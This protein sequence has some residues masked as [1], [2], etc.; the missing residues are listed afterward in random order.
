MKSKYEE[1]IVRRFAIT[2]TGSEAEEM[3]ATL[4]D[5]VAYGEVGYPP[6]VFQNLRKELDRM[7]AESE[8]K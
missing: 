2:L 5:W 6:T 7:I 3:A 4:R 8:D 1:E